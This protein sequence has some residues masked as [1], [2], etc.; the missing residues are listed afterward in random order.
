MTRPGRWRAE[1]GA[2]VCVLVA[3]ALIAGTLGASVADADAAISVDAATTIGSLE[4]RLGTQFVW[5]GGLDR[6][7]GTRAAFD[8][9]APALVRINVATLSPGLPLVMPAGVRRDDWNFTNL[10]SLVQDV[11]RG[12]AEVV[13]TVA[14][15][16]EWMWN[17]TT[18][19]I[20]DLTFR[21][22]AGYVARLVAYYNRGSF[23]AD[24]GRTITNP[25]G[26]ANRID[27]WEL[28]NEP[29]QPTGGC[30]RSANPN[31]TAPQYVTMWNATVPKMLAVD[32]S[33]RLVGPTTGNAIS[34]RDPDYLPTL[35]AGAVRKPDVVSFHGYGGWL[36]SQSDEL[37]FDGQLGYG[38]LA[39]IERGLAQVRAWAPGTPVWVTEMN[40]NSAWEQD[41]PAQ[42][43]WTAYGAAWGASAFLHLA[44]GGANAAF[45]YQFAHPDLRQFSLVDINTGQ[46]L[47]PYWRDYYLARY[48]PPGSRLLSVSSK[49]SQIEALAARPPGSR[50][51]HVLVVNRRVDDSASTGGSGSPATVRIKV[52]G[53][54]DVSSV[55]V[56]MLEASTP[57]QDGPAAV[58]LPADPSATVT[59]AGYG[60]ALLEFVGEEP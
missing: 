39:E 29:D 12:G 35:M 59:F 2:V 38:G 10:D 51:V 57:L 49:L 9:L 4:V 30:P 18:H 34:G 47:L 32:S 25:A 1:A 55:T 21:E 48:F 5:S 52:A 6:A 36:N 24:D 19:T 53:M 42:R 41:D 14:V 17:C 13:L 7:P 26:T 31:I 43:P 46:P 27:Y 11:H 44:L 22:F 45:Q 37:L 54:R 60:A 40:V 28:W 16:P 15:A 56:R 20:R 8:A 33:I 50:N 23:V 3:V 58:T